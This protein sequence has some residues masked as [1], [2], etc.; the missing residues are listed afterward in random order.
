MVADPTKREVGATPRARLLRANDTEPEYRFWGELRDRRLNGYKFVRQVP[1]GSYVV[2]FLCR[3]KHLVVELDGGQHGEE[4]A[5]SYDLQREEKMKALGF[6][7]LR[8]WNHEVLQQTEAV[9]E[10]IRQVAE[11][12]ALTPTLSR[13]RE[14]GQTGAMRAPWACAACAAR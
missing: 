3:D 5:G 8:F 14:R 1:L 11:A 2:D 4:A 7:T 12:L 10:K 13:E 6:Q 9:M